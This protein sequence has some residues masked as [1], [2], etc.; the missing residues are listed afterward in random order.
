MPWW[1]ER[2]AALGA[3]GDPSTLALGPL[4]HRREQLH[5][6]REN[7]VRKELEEDF[8]QLTGARQRWTDFEAHEL[9][10]HDALELAGEAV[11]ASLRSGALTHAGFRRAW[12][13][14]GFERHADC[15]GTPADDYLDG[16][17][18]LSRHARFATP[19]AF[20]MLN[21]AT[22]ASRVSDFLTE[23]KPGV[24]DVVFDLGSGS[25]KLAL[26]V[27]ASCDTQ[28][29]GVECEPSY[30]AEA[31]HAA[32]HLGLANVHFDTADVRDVNLASGS[33]FYLYYPFHG[34]VAATV[35]GTLGAL[36][37]Q[38]NISVYV[39]GPELEFGVH[40]LAQVESGAF[41]LDDRRG[42]FGEVLLLRSAR[43]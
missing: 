19:T 14:L 26:T 39:A 30:A 1:M 33:I 27:G 29:R 35:A 16:L 8:M 41:T 31:R 10:V 12:E 9:A 24:D 17:L 21:L 38:K 22:R 28:V 23:L 2:V 3:E 20:G 32:G 6:V 36:A 37:R 43:Q 13:S 5:L 11:A 18:F 7:V 42:E 40:F 4:W 34:S 25:G 15:G